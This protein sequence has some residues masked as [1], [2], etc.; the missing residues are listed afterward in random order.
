LSQEEVQLIHTIMTKRI[1]TYGNSLTETVEELPKEARAQKA[2]P[3]IIRGILEFISEDRLAWDQ[4]KQ[5][6]ALNIGTWKVSLA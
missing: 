2:T 5:M 4:I 1:K 6:G 3:R